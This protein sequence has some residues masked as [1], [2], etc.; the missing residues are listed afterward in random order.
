MQKK[1]DPQARTYQYFTEKRMNR[2][3]KTYFLIPR[4]T[5][6]YQYL[7]KRMNRLTKTQTE[8]GITHP[9]T[10]RS[11][12]A[13]ETMKKLV[14]FCSTFSL[15]TLAMTNTL[16]KTTTIQRRPNIRAQQF[17]PAGSS[18]AS[19][20]GNGSDSSFVVFDSNILEKKKYIIEEALT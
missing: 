12:T 10:K 8:K 7:K 15:T 14:T 18:D 4:R 5:R 13:K 20:F 1:Y 17:F 9:A 2:L 19:S 16:P 11:A 3:T 6:K